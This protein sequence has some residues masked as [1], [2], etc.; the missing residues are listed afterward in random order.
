VDRDPELGIDR[1]TSALLHFE[2]GQATFSCAGQ[3][4]PYQR[5]HIYGTRGRIEVEIPFNQPPDRPSRILFDDGRDLI[6]SGAETMEFTAVDQFSVQTERFV[7]AIRGRGTVPMT[8]EDSV[9]NMAVIDALVR[10]A[11]T[12]RWEMPNG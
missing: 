12:G 6:G 7:D 3:L 11:G 4:V 1:L 2:A 8:L 5:M 9:A 10:S